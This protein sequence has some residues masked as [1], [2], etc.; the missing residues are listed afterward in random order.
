MKLLHYFALGIYFSN[1]LFAINQ[2]TSR[3]VVE[4]LIQA[5]YQNQFRA[6]FKP[7]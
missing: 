2:T 5:R 1:I 7:N 4:K 3:M 6:P